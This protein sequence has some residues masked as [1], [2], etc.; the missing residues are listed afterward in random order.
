MPVTG[1]G[2]FA[3]LEGLFAYSIQ[4][5][6]H[7]QSLDDQHYDLNNKRIVVNRGGGELRTDAANPN[8]GR[9]R[10]AANQPV[11]ELPIL[12]AFLSLNYPS[13]QFSNQPDQPPIVPPTPK[14]PPPLPPPPGY[15]PIQNAPAYTPNTGYYPWSE[16]GFME[17]ELSDSIG[18]LVVSGLVKGRT[19]VNT[20][21][22]G[23][24]MQGA[25]FTGRY[26]WDQLVGFANESLPTGIITIQFDALL[27]AV[28]DYAFVQISADE[29][30]ISASGRVPRP[31]VGTGSMR[32]I[33]M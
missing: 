9:P 25:P 20:G 26:Q 1:Q 21:G 14:I 12:T 28:W 27:A 33:T 13:A 2:V 5:L 22:F 7:A 6:M 8:P 29:Y 32:R 24:L 15:F 30:I 19:R 17:F 18:G 3:R 23:G 4:G 11:P 31:A 16:T 10:P